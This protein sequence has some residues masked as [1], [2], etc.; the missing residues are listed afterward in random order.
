MRIS[1][2]PEAEA[3]TLGAMMIDEWAADQGAHLLRAEQFYSAANAAVFRALGSVRSRRGKSDVAIVLSELRRTGDSERHGIL[4]STLTAMVDLVLNVG[5]LPEYAREVRKAHLDREITSAISSASEEPKVEAIDRI[6]KLCVERESQDRAMLFRFSENLH[7]A[8]DSLSKEPP[9]RIH[10][11]FPS[12]DSRLH[13]LESGDLLTVGAR[14][15]YGKTAIMTKIALNLAKK[16]IPVLYFAG[17]MA[18]LQLVQR[19]LPIESRVEAWKFRR[20]V[21]KNEWS[22]VT[23][24]ASRLYELPFSIC[25][26]PSPS[27]QDIETATF[28]CG[29]AV[30][31]VDYLQR[32]TLPKADSH[33]IRVSHFMVGLKNF[34]RDRGIVGVLGSQL[35]RQTDRHQS[36]APVLADLQESASIEQESDQVIL[37]WTPDEEQETNSGCE[38][39]SIVAKNRHGPRG[40]VRLYFDKAHVDIVEPETQ[41]DLDEDYKMKAAGD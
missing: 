27:L 6:R 18:E 19:V 22:A 7:D 37:M 12:L 10:T 1:S 24:A 26:F 36:K 38:L 29:A 4:A 15:G 30:I 32:C 8:L 23:E 14:T 16:K 13:G 5:R 34:L 31:F 9:S 21:L 2:V 25:G 35:N 3:A 28:S 41:P 17:E 20:R 40:I 11:G 39:E 33:R